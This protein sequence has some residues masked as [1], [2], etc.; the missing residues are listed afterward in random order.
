MWESSS[1]GGVCRNVW[2]CGFPAVI[3]QEIGDIEKPGYVNT[4]GSIVGRE[5]SNIATDRVLERK[6][7]LHSGC[8]SI[9]RIQTQTSGGGAGKPAELAY[10]DLLEQVVTRR[11]GWIWK[12]D[13]N[14]GNVLC[15]HDCGMR[16]GIRMSLMQ[17]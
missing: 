16:R 17:S 8:I 15:T 6:M 7:G 12:S 9:A 5:R 3:R 11:E 14:D 2:L 1:P 10:I 4:V 13:C